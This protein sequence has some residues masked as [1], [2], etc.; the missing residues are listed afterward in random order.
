MIKKGIKAGEV[1]IRRG[2]KKVEGVIINKLTDPK[3]L[4][5][6]YPGVN[7]HTPLTRGPLEMQNNILHLKSLNAEYL[8]YCSSH[9]KET[10]VNSQFFFNKGGVK[11][12]PNPHDLLNEAVR[13]H[14][15]HTKTGTEEEREERE[16]RE[17]PEG[18]EGPEDISKYVNKLLKFFNLLDKLKDIYEIYLEKEEKLLDES[19]KDLDESI[20]DEYEIISIYK[21]DELE[22]K[23]NI[24]LGRSELESLKR[25]QKGQEDELKELEGDSDEVHLKRKE[26]Q[27]EIEKR[28]LKIKEKEGMLKDI[29]VNLDD[30]TNMR[31]DREK[32]VEELEDKVKRLCSDK[33]KNKERQLFC[34]KFA[35]FNS[36]A[37]ITK[38][39]EKILYYVSHSADIAKATITLKNASKKVENDPIPK[40]DELLQKRLEL[41][42]ALSSPSWTTFKYVLK[43]GVLVDILADYLKEM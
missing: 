37:Q 30:K 26:L 20:K 22:Y 7:K 34:K 31:Q 8:S 43:S 19:I 12:L 42:S 16:E 4:S 29:K 5:G 40:S 41:T 17:G 33:K 38:P 35:V 1:A 28:E 18:P 14:F 25:M 13:Q 15:F 2:V 9:L 39:R 32:K 24:E 23:K 3:L 27:D 6:G 10:K 36:L 11:S 21:K